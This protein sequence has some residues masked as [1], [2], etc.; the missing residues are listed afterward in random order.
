MLVAN[1]DAYFSCLNSYYKHNK[2]FKVKPR[3][4]KYLDKKGRFIC[5]IYRIVCIN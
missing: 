3:I 5:N 2:V 4:P 1:W